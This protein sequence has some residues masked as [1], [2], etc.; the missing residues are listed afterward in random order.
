MA[1]E[2]ACSFTASSRP[3]LHNRYFCFAQSMVQIIS[4]SLHFVKR[5]L[6]AGGIMEQQPKKR[7]RS[8]I[9]RS[10]RGVRLDRQRGAEWHLAQTAHQGEHRRAHPEPC[11]KAPVYRQPAGAWPAHSRSGLVGLM[12]PVYDNRYFSSMAQTFEA[13]V[14]SAAMADRRQRLSRSRGGAANGGDADLLFDRRA[15][16]R[17]A[18]DPDGVHEVCGALA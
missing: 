8:M 17:G 3:T 9:C 13:H 15:F 18:T 5:N 4:F 6:A 2:H 16:H 12:L 11:R 7:P 10:F 1:L 14:R